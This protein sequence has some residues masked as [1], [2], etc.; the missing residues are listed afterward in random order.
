MVKCFGFCLLCLS[1]LLKLRFTQN[2]QNKIEDTNMQNK[3][4]RL[5]NTKIFIK[6]EI[7]KNSQSLTPERYNSP[8]RSSIITGKNMRAVSFGHNNFILNNEGESLNISSISNKSFDDSYSQL[9]IPSPKKLNIYKSPKV[10]PEIFHVNQNEKM[11]KLKLA[12]PGL[13][14]S[15]NASATVK[16]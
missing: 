2:P 6:T 16:I 7:P 10:L 11:P 5:N 8:I 13:K 15:K 3:F 1:K 12:S 14:L 9:N 4:D